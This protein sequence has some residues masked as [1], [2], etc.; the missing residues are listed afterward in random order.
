MEVVACFANC[1]GFP[2]DFVRDEIDGGGYIRYVFDLKDNRSG[3]IY[4][5]LFARKAEG[6]WE[7]PF[8]DYRNDGDGMPLLSVLANP[9]LKT[10]VHYADIK[11]FR[12]IIEDELDRWSRNLFAMADCDSDLDDFDEYTRTFTRLV[13]EFEAAEEE[14]PKFGMYPLRP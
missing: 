12:D 4:E 6:M 2:V 9:P 8:L 3:R 10:A 13:E 5:N 14:W 7:L 11:E 1:A